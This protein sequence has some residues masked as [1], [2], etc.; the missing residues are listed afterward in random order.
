MMTLQDLPDIR[1][2]SINRSTVNAGLVI[3]DTRNV[4]LDIF[5][6]LI[7]S[8]L[9]DKDDAHL[10]GTVK[11]MLS[12][13]YIL[14]Y[15]ERTKRMVQTSYPDDRFLL[16]DTLDLAQDS[17]EWE[18]I[19]ELY[20]FDNI[21]RDS[22][23]RLSQV[24]DSYHMNSV[25]MGSFQFADLV[26]LNQR[27]TVHII[28]WDLVLRN[29]IQNRTLK[30]GKKLDAADRAMLGMVAATIDNIICVRFPIRHHRISVPPGHQVVM[31]T[32]SFI[33]EERA[34]P[35]DAAILSGEEVMV[36]FGATVPVLD[37]YS[38]EYRI[39]TTLTPK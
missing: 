4:F 34:S 32:K 39:M 28:A 35:A 16:V 38:I 7:R 9:V 14:G 17:L 30:P 15:D 19:E 11:L 31:F 20:G 36:P 24:F 13:A 33:V 10:L 21:E 26:Y 3:Q 6:D 5:G 18:P 29:L 22:I 1:S 2:W 8:G 37:V 25:T 27:E 12:D 23:E